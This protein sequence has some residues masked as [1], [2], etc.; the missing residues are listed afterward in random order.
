MDVYKSK[1]KGDNNMESM[2]INLGG[3]IFNKNFI[4][5][6]RKADLV[7]G[8]I[9]EHLIVI[10][11]KL[12]DEIVFKYNSYDERNKNY[13]ELVEKLKIET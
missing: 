13:E 7:N 5:H 12:E 11:K 3:F 2:F 6:I 4:Q 1:V 10:N 9:I 8:D